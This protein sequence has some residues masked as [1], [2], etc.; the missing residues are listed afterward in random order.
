MLFIL[1]L[2]IFAKIVIDL[3]FFLLFIII[4]INI[5]I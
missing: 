3:L 1:I 2:S 4:I 5:F